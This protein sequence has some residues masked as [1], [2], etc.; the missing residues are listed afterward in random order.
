MDSIDKGLPGAGRGLSCVVV[1]LA[2]AAGG[3]ARQQPD[4]A[5]PRATDTIAL[6]PQS[7]VISVPVS[8]DLGELRLALEREV[9]RT[10]WA[11]DR[12]GQTCAAPKK[13]K[14]LIVKIKTPTIKCRLVGLVTRGP[15]AISGSGENL[16][17]TMPIH[18]VIHARDIGGLLKQETA[19]A[20]ARVRALAHLDIQRDWS[21]TGKVDIKYDWTREPA[22]DLLGQHIVLTNQADAKLQG[23][24]A[25]L[26]RTLPR[27][28]AKLHFRQNVERSW[29]GAFTSLQ[30]NRSNPPVWM[31][32]T[33]QTLNYGGYAIDGQKVRLRLGM[34]ALTE[35]YVGDRPADP[36]P[37]PL[38]AVQR[39]AQ[40]A[41]ELLFYVPVVADYA[42]LE[43][44]VSKALTKRQTRPFE[45]PGIGPVNARF[46]NVTV[47]GTTGGR[48][49]VG[50]V[51]Q[52]EDAAGNFGKSSGT[53]WLTGKPVN[54]PNSRAVSFADLKVAGTTDRRTT[55]LMLRLANSPAL[56]TT[57]ADALAQN[58]A[59]DYDE[60]MG[61]VT[62]AIAEKRTG[63][64]VIRARIDDVRTGTLRAAGRGL[65]LPVWGKG[66]AGVELDTH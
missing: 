65:Y 54:A 23:V 60:L 56:A 51:L 63:D 29:R 19:T 50:V 16:V 59:H 40:P 61:K 11:I 45:V 25:R 47:Y 66:T 31:R 20:D 33:P 37:A 8:A 64:L 1:A 10:L 3:C 21:L 39:L 12:P 48:I 15:L 17:V 6:E 13:V 26:E 4:T 27:E 57:I 32:I 7:S 2:L 28:L 30:L 42:Q 49:A 41:G 53:V 62:R 14:V 46:G 36:Q 35:T 22:V 52:V 58:F 9:P 5:P 43:P 18:A 44:V 24:V 38:P 55:D 34:K